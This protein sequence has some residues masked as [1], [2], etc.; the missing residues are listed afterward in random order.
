MKQTSGEL[1]FFT[2]QDI[3]TGQRSSYYKI[4]IVRDAEGRDSKARL[5]EH[6][7]GNPRRL[8]VEAVLEKVPAVEYVETNLHYLYARKRVMGEW[9]KLSPTELQEAIAKANDLKAEME[10]NLPD[11][12]RAEELKKIASS[13][14]KIAPTHDSQY[15]FEEILAF[16]EVIDT[17]NNAL[18]K[19]DEYLYEAIEKGVVAPGVAKLQ[20]RSASKKFDANLLNSKY[21]DLYKKFSKTTSEVKG[22]FRLAAAGDF[23]P[24]ISTLQPEQVELITEFT[25]LV[26]SADHTLDTGFVLHG[27]YL[28]VLEVLQYAKYRAEIADV[29]LRVLTGDSDGIEGI[30]TWKR[31]LKESIT[32]DKAALKAEHQDEYAECHTEGKATEALIV[33]PK[34]AEALT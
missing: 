29:K 30:C 14:T 28:A 19:Y 32:F 27:K 13:G 12:Q 9:I 25:E 33:E 5:L 4:G 11:I 18:E 2:E 23:A 8:V 1:Y 7:T 31:T 24:D 15:W 21:P 17:C 34:I 16:N 20:P 10:A 26:E 6:Q 22:S 3:D